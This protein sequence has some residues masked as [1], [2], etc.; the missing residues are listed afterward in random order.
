VR[1]C[2]QCEFLEAQL[3]GSTHL[4][5]A[6]CYT[7]FFDLLS[8]LIWNYQGTTVHHGNAPPSQWQKDQA[9]GQY[10]REAIDKARAEGREDDADILT[11]LLKFLEDH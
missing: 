1:Q 10:Y 3:A 8:P 5:C 2:P 9:K 11:D 6:H 7:V 4:G